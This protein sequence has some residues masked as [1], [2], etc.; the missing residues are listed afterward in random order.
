MSGWY[1][2]C[3]ECN[4]ERGPD[5]RKTLLKFLAQQELCN[6]G[7]LG[8]RR[9]SELF[10]EEFEELRAILYPETSSGGQS[11]SARRR[12]ACGSGSGSGFG[13]GS[14]SGSGFGC[15]G[16]EA[17]SCAC[18][19]RALASPMRQSMPRARDCMCLAMSW[20]CADPFH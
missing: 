8:H 17:S 9:R 2:R 1:R 14:G 20:W 4:E 11:A 7:V 6:N 10:P 12:P 5:H 19:R 13:S 15:G 18:T 16:L 3:P